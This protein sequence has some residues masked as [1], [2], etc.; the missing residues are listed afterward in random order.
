M[1]ILEYPIYEHMDTHTACWP[2][3]IRLNIF[4]SKRLPTVESELI[5][6]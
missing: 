3:E 2:L 1:S 5:E 6:T 4:S